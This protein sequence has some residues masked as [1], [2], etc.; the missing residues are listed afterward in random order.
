MRAAAYDA[1]RIPIALR[2]LSA[3]PGLGI[4]ATVYDPA[5]ARGPMPGSAVALAAALLPELD[6][7]NRLRARRAE[8]LAARLSADT[9]FTPLL[10]ASGEIGIYPRLG[11]VAPTPAKRDAALVVLRSLG[12]TGMYP[13]PLDEI[14]ALRPHLVG[15]THC[16][17]ARDFCGR[18]LTLPCHAGLSGRRMDELVRLLRGL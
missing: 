1:A 14:P 2:A 4:G 3:I 8:A 6:D 12:A 15:D 17:G 7:A 11:L 13:T 18:L 10:A 9:D 16:L 5:F